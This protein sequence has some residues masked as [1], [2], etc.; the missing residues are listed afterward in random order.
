[1]VFSHQAPGGTT[2]I[3]YYVFDA[4]LIKYDL[5]VDFFSK[6]LYALFGNFAKIIILMVRLVI[7]F[8]EPMRRL[9]L[10]WG[11]KNIVLRILG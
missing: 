5:L 6:V 9:V 2:P 7:V 4:F 1:M 11:M 3:S 10:K 8:N